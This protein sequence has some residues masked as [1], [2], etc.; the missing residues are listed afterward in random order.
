MVLAGYMKV[1]QP[2]FVRKY[3]G[4]LINIH[5][6]LLPSFP[7]TDGVGDAL[8]YGVKVSGVTIHF[9]DEGVD[10]GPIIAQA[11]VPVLEDDD[12]ESLH[13]RIQKH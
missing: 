9:V 7:G 6:A 1:F 5:P 2:P 12:R 8:K 4:R 10:T 11:A 13:A 3:Y